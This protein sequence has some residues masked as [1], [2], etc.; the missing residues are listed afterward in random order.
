MS[1]R[2]KRTALFLTTGVLLMY[3]LSVAVILL[4]N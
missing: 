2:N 3:V 1:S 4:R